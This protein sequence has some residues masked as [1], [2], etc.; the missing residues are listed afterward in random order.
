MREIV[1][2]AIIDAKN[3][4]PAL[5]ALAGKDKFEWG[6]VVGTKEKYKVFACHEAQGDILRSKTKF[7]FAFAGSGGG[8]TCL[9]PLWLLQQIQKNPTGRFL[10]VSPTAKIYEDS[11]L[12]RHILDTFEGTVWEGDWRD[13]KKVYSLPTGGEIVVKTAEGDPRRVRG[14]Q[15]HAAVADECYIMS[16]EVWEEIRRRVSN[17]NGPILAVTTPDGNN[18]IYDI[19]QKAEAGDKDYYV[20]H[21]PKTANPTASIEDVQR[22]EK[23]LSEAK[24]RRMVLGE[25]A[26]LDGLCY[27]CFSDDKDIRYPVIKGNP[28]KDGLL[29]PP[30]RFFGGGDWGF[31]DPAAFLLFADCEDGVSYAIDEIYGTKITPDE[32]ARMVRKMVDRW[33]LK[34]DSRY[35]AL[36]GGGAFTTFYADTSRPEE[37]KMFKNAGIPIRNKRVSDIE[38]GIAVTDSWFRAGRLKVYSCCANLVR[39]LRGYQWDKDRRGGVKDTPVDKDNHTCDALRYAVSSQKYGIA[40]EPLEVEATETDVAKIERFGVTEV[41]LK[42]KERQQAKERYEAW[43]NKMLHL[44]AE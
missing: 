14:G 32:L 5:V 20:R 44:E 3:P 19:K 40:P 29:S 12:K 21:W 4:P 6:E 11:E 34:R 27:G 33:V 36:V 2:V 23:T 17:K 25:F 37:L 38:A 30:V 7:T 42:E 39:E 41:Q 31:A 10:V 26:T 43:F 8:K 28:F 13:A 1:Q 18:W 16:G 15:Y 24:Y 35:A 22:E 9:I